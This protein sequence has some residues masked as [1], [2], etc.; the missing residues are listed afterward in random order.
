MAPGQYDY[1]PGSQTGSG[2]A[3]GHQPQQD[4]GP[5]APG[6]QQGAPQGQLVLHLQKP[7]MGSASMITPS[8]TIDNF[9]AA[10]KWEDNVYTVPAGTRAITCEAR[11]LWPYGQARTSIDVAPGQTVRL[12]YA[13]PLVSFGSGAIGPEKQ[14]RP[15]KVIFGV[16]IA[17]VCLV[18]LIPVLIGVIAAAVG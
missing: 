5:S 18:I 4:F 2:P 7:G 11:Y 15:G 8:V 9:P 10:A 12:F 14:E 3:P 13:S 17:F 6:Q 16:I 1:A